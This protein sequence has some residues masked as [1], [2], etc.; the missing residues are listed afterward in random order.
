M[1][2]RLLYWELVGFGF[3]CLLGTVGHFLYEWTD[4]NR[5]IGA[6]FA[7]NES[8][9]EHMKLLFVPYF[10][11]VV[12]ECFSLAREME[13]FLA[14]K[15]TGAL[16]GIT[17]IPIIYYSLSGVFGK[18]PE[19]AGITIFFVASAIAF[20]VSHRVMKRD[21][22]RGT[23]WQAAGFLLLWGLLLLFVWCTYH[24]PLLPIFRD[25]LTGQYGMG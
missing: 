2:K 22:L 9:W 8:T 12:A 5:Y 7:V 23:V 13:N 4:E 14:A 18:L 20:S 15:A 6:F 19:W 11:Y 16:A 25:P 10:I 1:R 24:T 21:L 17:S 3:V